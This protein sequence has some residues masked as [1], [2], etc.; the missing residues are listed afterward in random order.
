[1][2]VGTKILVVLSFVTLINQFGCGGEEVPAAVPAITPVSVVT[3]DAVPQ[4]L[5]R[6]PEV[7][8][9]F[10]KSES[11][12]DIVK[13]TPELIAGLRRNLNNF[14]GVEVVRFSRRNSSIWSD[15]S[16]RFFWGPQPLIKA[17]VPPDL[18]TAPLSAKLYQNEKDEYLANARSDYERE[19]LRILAAYNGRVDH[20]MDRLK[21]YLLEMPTVPAVCTNFISLRARLEEE[22]RSRNLVI[23][24]GWADCR[25]EQST[26]TNP[27]FTGKVTVVLV[28]RHLDGPPD[29]MAFGQRK[30]YMHQIFPGADIVPAVAS[31]RAIDSLLH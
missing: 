25:D 4:N 7:W 8:R 26:S 19:N 11:E 24:D 17:F 9:D 3:S 21:H 22:N 13:T 15:N 12:D 28:T 6:I 14:D 18:N 20:E 30:E 1:M 29:D 5:D 16:E 23:T 2:K 27:R 10:S 31:E